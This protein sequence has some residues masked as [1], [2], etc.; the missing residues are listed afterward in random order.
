MWG[1]SYSHDD[2]HF[3]KNQIKPKICYI[4]WVKDELFVKKRQNRQRYKNNSL[5]IPSYFPKYFVAENRKCKKCVF[6]SYLNFTKFTQNKSPLCYFMFLF[7]LHYI[8]RAKLAKRSLMW[9][10]AETETIKEIVSPPLHFCIFVR[11]LYFCNF[12]FW[13][14]TMFIHLILIF[15]C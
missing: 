11:V 6:M 7:K 10:S 8:R 14:F 15:L 9:C 12:C 13:Y 4:Y 3:I 1:F 2:C 5:C